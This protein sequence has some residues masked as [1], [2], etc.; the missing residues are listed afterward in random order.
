[1]KRQ[2]WC[3]VFL[4]FGAAAVTTSNTGYLI[5]GAKHVFTL[6]DFVHADIHTQRDT[7]VEMLKNKELS[8]AKIAEL[9]E[10]DERHVVAVDSIYRDPLALGREQ[11]IDSFIKLVIS[12]YEGS[13]P[14]E[15]EEMLK[16]GR[17]IGAISLIAG[18]AGL[19]ILF[20]H[21]ALHALDRMARARP[22]SLLAKF[23]VV[24]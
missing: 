7:L 20:G 2:H 1:M 4:F 15:A 22:N 3:A 10:V 5:P 13:H 24:W 14:A 11:Q 17:R 9:L 19:Y 21:G 16:I 8:H 6:A 18:C 12:H 23:F